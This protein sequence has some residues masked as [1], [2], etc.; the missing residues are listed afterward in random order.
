MSRAEVAKINE[1]RKQVRAAMEKLRLARKTY[2]EVC[3]S[4]KAS[5]SPSRKLIFA[6]LRK[7]TEPFETMM[8]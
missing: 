8:S 7:E 5:D 6:E 1:A 2:R 3:D 4:E